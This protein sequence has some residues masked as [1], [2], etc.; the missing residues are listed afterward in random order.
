VIFMSSLL[1]RVAAPPLG[2]Y[3]S[4][5]HAIEGIADAMRMEVARDGIDVVVIEPG[6]I[7]SSMLDEAQRKAESY[8]TGIYAEA[9][10]VASEGL[11]LTDFL[12]ADPR[13]VARVV[14]QAIDARHPQ[15]RHLV[16]YDAQI[17]GRLSP[18]LPCWLSDRVTRVVQGL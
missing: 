13:R 6:G 2:W 1:G 7:R 14:V 15:S 8:E 5:K 18:L 17:I 12:R 3:A 16:G 4:A 10:R 9:H 11:R